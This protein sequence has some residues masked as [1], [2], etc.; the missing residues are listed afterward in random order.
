METVSRVTDIA[1]LLSA[2]MK[3]DPAA[4]EQMSQ[5]TKPLYSVIQR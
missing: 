3:W 5:I 2:V 4:V 1:H